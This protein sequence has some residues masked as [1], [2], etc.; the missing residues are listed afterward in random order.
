MAPVRAVLRPLGPEARLS[1]GSLLRRPSH[2]AGVG[3]CLRTAASRRP[4]DVAGPRA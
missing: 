4:A 1:P 3:A 2:P